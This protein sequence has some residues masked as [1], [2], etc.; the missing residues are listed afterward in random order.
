MRF[1]PRCEAVMD[2]VEVV[3]PQCG[4]RH[5]EQVVYRAGYEPQELLD[6]G[7]SPRLVQFVFLDPKPDPFRYWCEG[8]EAGWACVIPPD[9]D[10][11]YPLWTCDADVTPCGY[12]GGGGSSSGCTTTTPSPC[13][14]GGPNRA[15]SPT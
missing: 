13:N 14:S 10:G 7:L 15:Y 9:V 6:L 8:R 2:A 12:G 11:V 4:H 5:R 1:C 3:C